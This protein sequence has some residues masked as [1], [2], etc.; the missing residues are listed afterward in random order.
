[1]NHIRYQCLQFVWPIVK[2]I[3]AMVLLTAQ[4]LQAQMSQAQSHQG[5]PYRTPVNPSTIHQSPENRSSD[6]S[7]STVATSRGQAPGFPSDAQL[8]M[9]EDGT[10]VPAAVAA[11]ETQHSAK[12]QPVNYGEAINSKPRRLVLANRNVNKTGI[13]QDGRTRF[14]RTVS[15]LGIVGGLMVGFIWWT[16]KNQGESTLASASDLVQVLGRVSLDSK[17]KAHIVRFGDRL[18]LLSL[19]GNAVSKLGEIDASDGGAR[20]TT[21]SRE[22]Q[23]VSSK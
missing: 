3:A 8:R 21:A 18:L 6:T 14:I 1:M 15:S 22:T 20:L 2:R 10:L 4:M 17:H 19:E 12:I 5:L 7:W 11:R 23:R 16:R 13:W 9:A